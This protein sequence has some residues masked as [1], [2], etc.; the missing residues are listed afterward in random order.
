VSVLPSVNPRRREEDPRDGDPAMF[1]LTLEGS[2]VASARVGGLELS[3][4]CV[5]T[6]Q[7]DERGWFTLPELPSPYLVCRPQMSQSKKPPCSQA[8]TCS[9]TSSSSGLP[10]SNSFRV[11]DRAR[12]SALV[13]SALDVCVL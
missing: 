12:E 1:L 4:R 10:P 7:G 11:L 13:M 9:H 2:D 3:Y 5:G 8:C 6:G